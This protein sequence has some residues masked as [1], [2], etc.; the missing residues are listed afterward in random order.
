MNDLSACIQEVGK[1][2]RDIIAADVVHFSA[3]R[4]DVG[5]LILVTA[6]RVH[7]KTLEEK[8]K[9]FLVFKTC[10]EVLHFGVIKK[11]LALVVNVVEVLSSLGR[12]GLALNIA[13]MP[14]K[15]VQYPKS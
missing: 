9:E 2:N 13:H 8:R 6:L 12:E 10:D 3:T 4:R 5:K 14:T 1:D 15:P 11:K 7:A